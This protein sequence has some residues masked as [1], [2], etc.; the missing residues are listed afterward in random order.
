MQSLRIKG[1][2]IHQIGLPYHW[3]SNGLVRG[4]AAN[5]LIGFVADPNVSIQESKAFTVMI[6]A[7]RKRKQRRPVREIDPRY[8]ERDLPIARN[9]PESQHGFK[10][11]ESMEG[12]N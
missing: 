2:V 6:E 3:A 8:G 12:N 10:D 4:D 1:R 11:A 5:E 7:G 9:K